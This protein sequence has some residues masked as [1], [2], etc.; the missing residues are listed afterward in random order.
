MVCFCVAS[1][2]YKVHCCYL[3]IL[4]PASV[5]HIGNR[6]NWPLIYDVLQ[7][8]VCAY[9]VLIE[10]MNITFISHKWETAMTSHGHVTTASLKQANKEY[11]EGHFLS[12]C[13][14]P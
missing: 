14:D 8:N 10:D 1:Y 9:A 5:V 6:N 11:T 13:I 7:V 12:A 3:T 2:H 4:I